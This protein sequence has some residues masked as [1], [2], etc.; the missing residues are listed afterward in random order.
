MINVRTSATLATAAFMYAALASAAGSDAENIAGW[1]S[2]GAAH[3]SSVDHERRRRHARNVILFIGDGMG[4]ATVT[5]IRIRAG[6]LEGGSG[7]EKVL[8][9]EAFPHSALIKTYNVDAQT[10]DS[11][12]TMSAIMTGAK[13]RA[14]VISVDAS[15]ARGDCGAS[16][17]H[18]VTTL[19]ERAERAGRATGIISTARVTHATPAA[20]YAH[21]ADR[22]WEA[23]TPVPACRDIAMQLLDF[24]AGDGIDVVFGGGRQMFLPAEV[25]DPED[26]TRH[27]LRRDGRNLIEEWQQRHPTGH[28]VWN[29]A[30]F[31]ALRPDRN[32]PVLGLFEPSHM[33]F[34]TDR[35][36]DTGGEP[37]LASMTSRA[38][39]LLSH[40]RHGYF[41]MV[42]AGRID[43][44]HHAGNAYRAL[45]DGVALAEA[46]TA[47]VEKTRARDTLIIV[48]A[49]HAH[50]LTL[51]GYAR[52]GAP[53]LGLVDAGPYGLMRDTNGLP[54]TILNYANGPGYRPGRTDLSGVDTAAP[55]YRQEA[56]VPL[57]SETHS[58]VDVAAYARGPGAQYVTG[59]LEQPML[60]Y[61]MAHALRLDR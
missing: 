34:E 20:T 53:I 26:P 32:G 29:Q 31:D 39:D 61:I 57:T 41:L 24:D 51:S 22:D 16:Q 42:E 25:P 11:A 10:P 23:A 54:Y 33:K 3:L 7:E 19:L 17:G 60:Y 46:V 1:R 50:T 14:G 44:A 8:P 13:T 15:V 36:G 5:A 58:G 35:T 49:D 38:I 18:A 59:V 55:D 52:R 27:G 40:S 30:G 48:T 56:T 37:S 47:A 21:S 6:Q 4:V 12:G 43:H 45:A 28:Y 2:A 9:W